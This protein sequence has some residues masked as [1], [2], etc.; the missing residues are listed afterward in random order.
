MTQAEMTVNS[1]LVPTVGLPAWICE[2]TTMAL[3]AAEPGG[4]KGFDQFP[5]KRG[6]YYASA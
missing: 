2:A 1:Q 6:P 4:E 3:G 5:G